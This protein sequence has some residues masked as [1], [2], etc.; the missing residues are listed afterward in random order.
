MSKDDSIDFKS[1]SFIVIESVVTGSFVDE[2]V[3]KDTVV[4]ETV[5]I[6]TIEDIV[7][8]E[9]IEA[10]VDIETVVVDT[11]VVEDETIE[12]S[13]DIETV[14]IDTVVVE[15]DVKA[16]MGDETFNSEFVESKALAE[17][18]FISVGT[19]VDL[20]VVLLLGFIVV[21]T[22]EGSFSLKFEPIGRNVEY[23]SLD[24]IIVDLK[25]LFVDVNSGR[26]KLES[27]V[28]DGGLFEVK[29]ERLFG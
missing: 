15:N 26:T 2:I 1:E 8:D 11:V 17:S 10:R 28:V 3:V 27:S 21:D 14:I 24:G 4:D 29:F 18:V 5:V 20:K 25:L 6:D 23:F 7:E 22:K 12:D 16:G 13:V 19:E 9:T